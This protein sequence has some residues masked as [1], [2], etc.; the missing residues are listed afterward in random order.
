MRTHNPYS[1]HQRELFVI[2][3]AISSCTQA[4][5]SRNP[6]SRNQKADRSGGRASILSTSY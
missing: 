4:L 3:V 5:F 2:F 6:H 1:I